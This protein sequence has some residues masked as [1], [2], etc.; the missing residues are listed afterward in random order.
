MIDAPLNFK[1]AF[2]LFAL[3]NWLMHPVVS[4]VVVLLA[5]VTVPSPAAERPNILFLFAD[6]Q[7]A[8]TI[9]AWGN[10]RIRTPLVNRWHKQ[11]VR[12]L[13]PRPAPLTEREIEEN[14]AYFET[15]DYRIGYEA[16]M[17]KK[18]PRFVGR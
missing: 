9:G 7:R 15:E 1:L 18:K 14:F 6:D 16:F 13:M 3:I 8:D 2:I 5:L 17:R 11:F 10:K 12:R 4:V